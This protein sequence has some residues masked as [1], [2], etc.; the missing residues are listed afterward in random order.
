[1]NTQQ[2]D[3]NY[4]SE[5]GIDQS[6]LECASPRTKLAKVCALL[7]AAYSYQRTY[8]PEEPLPM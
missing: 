3:S 8:L 2:E 4:Q 6:R 7:H 1:M 5:Y